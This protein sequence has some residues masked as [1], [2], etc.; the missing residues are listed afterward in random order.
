MFKR[1]LVPLDG[2]SLAE[3]ILP[4]VQELART[5]GAE[6]FLVRAVA[7]HVFPGVDPRAGGRR[8]PESGGVCR[9]GGRGGFAMPASRI[10][11]A[12]RYGEPL[13]KSLAISGRTR[14]TWWR[15]RQHGRSG[16]SRLVLGASRSRWSATPPSRSSSC[17]RERVEARRGRRPIMEQWI[18][19]A[20]DCSMR[21]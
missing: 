17:G 15:C 18:T 3:A 21:R 7:A 16:L 14:P 4:Q 12:V 8:R 11:T 10:H 6:L 20:T 5:L 13:R 19:S 1:I 9:G 2:S